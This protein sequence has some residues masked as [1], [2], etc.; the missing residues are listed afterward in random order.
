MYAEKN[1]RLI[2]MST[3]LLYSI[4]YVKWILSNITIKVIYINKLCIGN[5]IDFTNKT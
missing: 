2:I 4:V 1:V 3:T 5:I